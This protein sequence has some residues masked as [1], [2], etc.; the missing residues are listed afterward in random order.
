MIIK[1]MIT[2]PVYIFPRA[3]LALFQSK[4]TILISIVM[5]AATNRQDYSPTY[6]P[7]DAY[8]KRI[9]LLY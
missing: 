3:N 9:Y 8:G 5:G 1:N 7:K 4:M 6:T 2:N